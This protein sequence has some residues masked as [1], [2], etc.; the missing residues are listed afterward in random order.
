[1]KMLHLKWEYELKPTPMDFTSDPSLGS[2]TYPASSTAQS[3]TA[4]G[5]MRQCAFFAAVSP[6]L[7]ALL[8]GREEREHK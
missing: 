1:M 4:H 7:G 8:G 3:I 5:I 6:A 2:L